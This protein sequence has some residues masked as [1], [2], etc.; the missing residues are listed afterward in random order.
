MSVIA[1]LSKLIA[2]HL[3][4]DFIPSDTTV[5]NIF[6]HGYGDDQSRWIPMKKRFIKEGFWAFVTPLFVGLE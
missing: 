3:P 4:V 1:N 5:V 2:E 6:V